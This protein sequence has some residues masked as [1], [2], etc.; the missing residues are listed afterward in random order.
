MS[1]QQARKAA[2]IV[3]GL[4]AFGAAYYLMRSPDSRRKAWQFAR[5]AVRASGALLI[6]EARKAWQQD[7]PRDGLEASPDSAV[8]RH[9]I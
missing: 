5:M 3:I 4:V 2:N 1:D 9:A 8:R 6:A 7:E